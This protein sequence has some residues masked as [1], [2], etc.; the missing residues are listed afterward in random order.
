VSKPSD[1]RLPCLRIGFAPMPAVHHSEKSNLMHGRHLFKRA[2]FVASCVPLDGTPSSLWTGTSLLL[3]Q[4]ARLVVRRPEIQIAVLQLERGD[5]VR[6]SALPSLVKSS[7]LSRS[8]ACGSR[9]FTAS[10]SRLAGELRSKCLS[11]CAFSVGPRRSR[12]SS[13]PR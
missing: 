10:N 4:F 13:A 11:R 9:P 3:P 12:H 6:Q 1:L 5:Q 8:P 2:R 7:K